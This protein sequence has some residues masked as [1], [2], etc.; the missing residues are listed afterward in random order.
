MS[1]APQ[2]ELISIDNYLA[3]EQIAKRKHEFVDGVVYAMVGA[4]NAH[5][6]IA[7]NATVSLGGQLR[8]RPCQ[9][10]NSDTKVRIRQFA[11]HALLLS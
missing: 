2:S 1:S 7:T 5:N 3:G 8:G 4:T 9:V 10:F 11:R 6:R